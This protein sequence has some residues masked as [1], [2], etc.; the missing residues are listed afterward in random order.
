MLEPQ[1]LPTQKQFHQKAVL[2]DSGKYFPHIKN[3]V[4]FV[5]TDHFV[6]NAGTK[7]RLGPA[8]CHRKTVC[9]YTTTHSKYLT[10]KSFKKS[11]WTSAPVLGA[12]R[13]KFGK[14]LKGINYC[15]KLLKEA[16]REEAERGNNNISCKGLFF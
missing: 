6:F 10:E 11:F 12:I 16:L 14:Y 1:L 13:P 7:L 3:S 9:F 8:H 2:L 15:S 4:I 5:F